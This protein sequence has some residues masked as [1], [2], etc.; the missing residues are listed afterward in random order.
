MCV[1]Q[2]LN[3]H[4]TEFIFNVGILTIKPKHRIQSTTATNKG[5][6]NPT[7]R[8]TLIS[9][10]VRGEN[11][12]RWLSAGPLEVSSPLNHTTHKRKAADICPTQACV[13]SPLELPCP[14]PSPTSTREQ[15]FVPYTGL[16]TEAISFSLHQRFKFFWKEN[17]HTAMHFLSLCLT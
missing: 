6:E 12:S 16:G 1:M 5:Q 7:L 10:C 9:D 15:M 14:V 13:P 3:S 4:P 2:L 8:Q 17:T 11:E